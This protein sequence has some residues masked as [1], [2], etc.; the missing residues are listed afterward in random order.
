M[1]VVPDAPWRALRV[2]P[3]AAPDAV[4]AALFRAG[5]QG[6]QEDGPSL[7]THFPPGT[8]LAPVRAAV[9]A[10][11]PGA[12]I[13]E[14]DAPAADWS[15]WRVSV[16]VHR[17]GALRVAPPW[18]A[19]GLDAATTIVIDPAMAFGTGEHPTTRGALRLM[20]GEG[21][22]R[23]G[24]VVADLG[25][26]SAVLAIA[27]VK[28][29]ASRVAAIELEPDAAGSAAENVAR[30]GVEGAVHYIVGDAALL[31]PLVA[32][33]RVILANIVSSVLA[34]L[35][36]TMRAALAPGGVAVLGGMLVE[37]RAPMRDIL[38]A[39][40]W[41]VRAQDVEGEWWSAVVAP[42]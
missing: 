15:V 35:L 14:G 12:E 41:S 42:A 36:P 24:D 37:E 39:G 19:G 1:S 7:V 2:T 30:N 13:S 38:A 25:A 20:Q 40:G 34:V 27:A 26:G 11:D 23:P 32:P 31:L 9:L 6:V 33:V 8:E 3:A 22:I 18:L 5:S 4:L 10:A 21:V 28:L 16:G 17:V 29:G